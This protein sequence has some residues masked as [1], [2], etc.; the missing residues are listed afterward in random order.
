MR[1]GQ[2][3]LKSIDVRQELTASEAEN[4][5]GALRQKLASVFDVYVLSFCIRIAPDGASIYAAIKFKTRACRPPTLPL[6]NS[7]SGLLQLH[8]IDHYVIFS[9]ANPPKPPSSTQKSI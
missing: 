9:D 8:N 3:L 1:A 4:R 5:L 7:S 2:K 6:A